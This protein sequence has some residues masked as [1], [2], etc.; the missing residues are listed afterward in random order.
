MTINNF[1]YLLFVITNKK[2]VCTYFSINIIIILKYLTKNSNAFSC[3]TYEKIVQQLTN[4]IK[5]LSEK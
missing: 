3:T 1:I 5:H 4:T 2:N